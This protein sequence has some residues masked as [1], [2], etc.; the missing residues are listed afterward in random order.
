MAEEK[1]FDDHVDDVRD[2]NDTE[3]G[4]R[5]EELERK[6]NRQ[7][8]EP[9]YSRLSVKQKWIVGA[10]AMLLVGI[11]GVAASPDQPLTSFLVFAPM[12]G[13]ILWVTITKSGIAFRESI[14]EELED[15]SQQQQQQ[16]ST[17]Q[18]QS[19]KIICQNCGWKNPAE[20]NY[21]HDCGNEI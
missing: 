1:T 9:L 8:V 18:S 14:S 6:A 15:D 19:N 5:I 17:T 3:M 7:D 13:I 10:A 11:A 2:S 20:N 4:E 16:I 21:C 12:T